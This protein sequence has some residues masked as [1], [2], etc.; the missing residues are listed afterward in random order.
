MGEHVDSDER[1][2]EYPNEGAVL[3]IEEHA[4]EQQT[5]TEQEPT[6]QETEAEKQEPKV[7][8]YPVPRSGGRAPAWAQV[9]AGLKIPKGTTVWFLRFR[10]E[11]TTTPQK[12]ERQCILWPLTLADELLAIERAKSHE[13]QSRL[14]HEFAKQMIRAVDGHRVN[15]DGLPGP[16]SIDVWWR[17]VGPKVRQ[18][19]QRLWMQLHSFDQREQQDFFESCIASVATG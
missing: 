3:E 19:I 5:E 13:S 15:W 7:L 16:G 12:G 17:E 14:N 18:Q 11:W 1:G 6:D 10:E 8:T 9:P 2:G 4:Q